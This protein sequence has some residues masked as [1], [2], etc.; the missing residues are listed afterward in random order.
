[1]KEA[2]YYRL[3]DNA[4]RCKLCPHHCLIHNNNVGLCKVRYNQNNKLWALNYGRIS[5]KN[6]DPIEKKPLFHFYPDSNIYSIGSIG[7]NLSCPFCQ[8]Y[9]I[10]QPKEFRLGR[11]PEEVVDM[12][13]AK[14]SVDDI[15]KDA[16]AAKKYGNIGIAYTYNEPFMSY[17]FLLDCCIK[18]KENG[19]K[20][21]IVTNGMINPNPLEKIL[22]FIDAAN[23]DLKGIRQEVYAKLGGK[24]KPVLNT[25]KTMVKSCHIEITNLI[26]PGLNDS[27]DDILSLTNWIVKNLG[28]EIPLHFSRYFPM[29]NYTVPSTNIDKLKQAETIARQKGIEFVYLGNV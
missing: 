17:E 26:V 1:M 10:A 12:L 2:L 11:P 14:R 5:S 22:P 29:Y 18:A 28:K 16:I 20:N 24:L 23:I 4:I 9:Q 25:I 19:L 6:L 13:T 15:V 7:C 3:E 21:I 27:N 8:N